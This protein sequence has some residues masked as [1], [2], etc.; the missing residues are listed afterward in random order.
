MMKS[1]V[2]SNGTALSTNWAEVGSKKMEV[3]PPDGM[4]A[5]KYN[6]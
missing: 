4:T 5:K 2:E 6:E 3:T 1:F